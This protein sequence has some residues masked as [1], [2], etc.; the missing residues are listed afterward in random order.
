M[1]LMVGDNNLTANKDYKHIMK[2]LQN[3]LLRKMGIMVNGVHVTLA[4]LCFH[5]KQNGVPKHRLDYLLNPSDHQNVPL[6]YSLLKE[7]WS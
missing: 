3:L 1:N 5:L 7:V 6:C 2:R 4:L